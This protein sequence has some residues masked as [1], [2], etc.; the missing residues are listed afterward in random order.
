MALSVTLMAADRDPVA[1]GVKVTLI[2][3]LADA[4]NELPQVLVSAKS[5]ALVPVMVMLVMASA[6]VP[7]FVKV[8]VLAALLLPTVTVPNE[9]D[10]GESFAVVPVPL[11]ETFCGL[12]VALSETLSDAEESTPVVLGLKVTLIV[13][14]AEAASEVLHVLVCA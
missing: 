14:F 11:N 2:V 4:A 3:Q 12:P 1:P 10:S 13:Q 7:P 8:T 5:L 9:S 6:L